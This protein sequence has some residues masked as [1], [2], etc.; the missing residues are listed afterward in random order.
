MGEIGKKEGVRCGDIVCNEGRCETYKGEVIEA[1]KKDGFA[2]VKVGIPRKQ[3]ERAVGAF[4]NFQTL[5]EGVRSR[6]ALCHEG[7]DRVILGMGIRKPESD[8]DKEHKEYFHY[9]PH[10]LQH[11]KKEL[12]AAGP[13]ARAFIE[14][15]DKL[16]VAVAKKV[17]SFVKGDLKK[18][19]PGMN[20]EQRFLK[21]GDPIVTLRFLAYQSQ[22]EGEHLAKPH[23][24]RGTMTLALGE[25]APGLWL[26]KPDDTLHHV[27]HQEGVAVFFPGYG[28]NHCIDPSIEPTLHG[29]KQTERAVPHKDVSR[30]A[31]VAFTDL[32]DGPLPSKKETVGV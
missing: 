24:D 29:V 11:L 12:D 28:F 32:I 13:E 31:V 27:T 20:I 23:V 26:K 19:Y 30:W 5:P 22:G 7:S 14:E 9:H 18:A 2:E 8:S 25:S 10:L 17:R 16:W 21:N 1:W 3:I 15:A 4:F 6:I